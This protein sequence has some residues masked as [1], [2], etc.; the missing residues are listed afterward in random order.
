[1]VHDAWINNLQQ[2]HYAKGR[3]HTMFAMTLRMRRV[4]G[5][6]LRVL[7]AIEGPLNP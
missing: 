4:S 5:E 3:L 2:V 6:A 7:R 1:M